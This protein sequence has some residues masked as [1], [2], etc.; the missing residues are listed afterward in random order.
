MTKSKSAAGKFAIVGV[1]GIKNA[2]FDRLQR[3][4][5]LRFSNAWSRSIS[6]NFAVKESLFDIVAA[7][8]CGGMRELAGL[9]PKRL[10]V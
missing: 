6:S 5:G 2:I 3:A 10:D 9:A 1:D 4:R 8:R 7:C